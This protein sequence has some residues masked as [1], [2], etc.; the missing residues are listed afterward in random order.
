MRFMCFLLLCAFSLFLHHALKARNF[1]KIQFIFLWLLVFW[2]SFLEQTGLIQ[3][4]KDLYLCLLIVLY[5]E[6]L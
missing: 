2:V 4:H 1:N 6:L 3:D 5:F